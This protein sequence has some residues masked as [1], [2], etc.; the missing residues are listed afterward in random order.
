MSI[1]LVPAPSAQPVSQASDRGYLAWSL[2]PSALSGGTALATAGTLYLTRIRRVPAGT[3]SNL[4]VLLSA[5]GVT[6]TAGQCF[7]ALFDASGTWLRSTADQATAWA[8]PGFK[9]MALTAPVTHTGG[10]LYAGLWF[11]GT[12]GPSIYRSSDTSS[13]MN[14]AGLSSPNLETATADTGLTTTAPASFG[15]QTASSFHNWVAVS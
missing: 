2:P 11:N 10:D 12:T 3:V 8:S 1:N 4:V 7:A 14:N 5:A 9:T 6:L 15:A 13:A